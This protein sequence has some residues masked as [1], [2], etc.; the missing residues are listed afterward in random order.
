MDV[1]FRKPAVD[2]SIHKDGYFGPRMNLQPANR[3]KHVLAQSNMEVGNAPLI[4]V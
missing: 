3:V 4:S 2:L 1:H